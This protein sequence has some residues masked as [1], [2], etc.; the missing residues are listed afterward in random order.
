MQAKELKF[1]MISSITLKL[2]DAGGSYYDDLNVCPQKGSKS[3]RAFLLATGQ[4]RS[5]LQREQFMEQVT[6]IK[7]TEA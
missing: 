2:P 3:N 6:V 5:I 7:Y 4:S 1:L